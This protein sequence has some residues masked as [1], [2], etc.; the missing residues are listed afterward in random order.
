MKEKRKLQK[1]KKKI[2]RKLETPESQPIQ[3]K[4]SIPILIS[5][6]I[7]LHFSWRKEF[8]LLNSRLPKPTF[9]HLSVYFSLPSDGYA[10]SDQRS[11]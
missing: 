8:H 11:V 9:T 1:Q 3:M 6:V 2:N 5:F 10:K 4:F 7:G